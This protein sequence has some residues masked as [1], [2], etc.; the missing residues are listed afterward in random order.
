VSTAG[1]EYDEPL[2]PDD[3]ERL[4]PVEPHD[5]LEPLLDRDEPLEPLLDRDEPLEPHEDPPE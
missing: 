1:L 3:D 2:D 4:E 5:Q